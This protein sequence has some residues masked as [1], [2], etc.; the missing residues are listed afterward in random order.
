MKRN[1]QGGVL[2]IVIV[3]IAVAGAAFYFFSAPF[4]T[5][6]NEITRQATKWTPENI[7]KDPVGYL[8]WAVSECDQLEDKLDAR[9]IALNTKINQSRREI[10]EKTSERASFDG[11]LKELKTAYRMASEDDVWPVE[12]RGAKLTEEQTKSRIVETHQRIAQLTSVIDTYESALNKMLNSL[13][14][15]GN[16]LSETAK[17]KRKLNGEVEI[18][19]VKKEVSGLD[20]VS[21]SVSAIIDTTEALIS[22]NGAHDQAPSIDELVTPA[23]SEKMNQ[24]FDAIMAN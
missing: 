8:T 6:V 22:S 14:D 9:I 16:K 15:V 23:P 2:L 12:V 21:D 10:M 20:E 18:A 24:E 17:L 4:K 5:K 3:L 13:T 11:L 19:R 7:Q 1:N